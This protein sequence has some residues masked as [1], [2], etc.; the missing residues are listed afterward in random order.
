MDNSM[1]TCSCKYKSLIIIV[2]LLLVNTLAFAQDN[3]IRNF[4]TIG[5][6]LFKKFKLSEVKDIRKAYQER[7]DLYTRRLD[8]LRKSSLDINQAII[9]RKD[10]IVVG[11][12]AILIRLAEFYYEEA[13]EAYFKANENYDL[14]YQKYDSLLTLFDEGKLDAL[15]IEPRPA[16]YDY[17]KPIEVYRRIAND[18]PAGQYAD[19][20][21]YNIAYLYNEMEEGITARKI[22]QELLEKYP[23]SDYA[24]DAYLNLGDYY[25]QPRENK[26][27]DESIVELQK[28]IKLY[29]KILKF[30][31]SKAYSE[32]LYKLGW[33]YYK[34]TVSDSTLYDDAIFYFW[35]SVEDIAMGKKYDPQG[36]ITLANV[37]PEAIEYIAI[38]FSDKRYA[39]DGVRST[40]KFVQ[41]IE[42][43]LGDRDY[44]VLIM[45]S[46]GDKYYEREERENAIRSYETL[47]DMY[48]LY[49]DAPSISKKIVDTYLQD[50]K[51]QQAY[52]ERQRLYQDYNTNSEW[53]KKIE[54]SDYAN[55]FEKLKKAYKMSEEAL[56]ANIF[57]DYQYANENYG[58]LVAQGKYNKV[59][60]EIKQYLALFPIDSSAY[61]LNWALAQIL[62]QKEHRYSEA[63]DEYLKVCNDYY[64][65]NHQ[66]A[67][68]L[69]AISVAQ[70]MAGV[71]SA[72]SDSLTTK[73]VELEALRAQEMN[74]DEQ[75]LIYAFDNYLR[76]FPEGEYAPTALAAAG[77]LYFNNNQFNQAKIYLQT[78]VK[79]FPGAKERNLAYKSIM[80][81]YFALGKYRDSELIANK[82]I[83]MPNV[84]EEMREGAKAR[85][86]ASIFKNAEK[87][88]R[89]KQ[90]V[91]SGYEYRRLA[92]TYPASKF[93]D[94]S[95]V[96]GA[97]AFEEGN[98]WKLAIETYNIL[99]TDFPNSEFVKRA[100]INIA[101]DYKE[102]DDDLA[103]G[104]SY[105]NLYN[106]FSKDDDAEN[107]LYNASLYYEKAKAWEE[108]ILANDLFVNRFPNSPESDFLLFNN[109]GFYLK[110]DRLEDA[111]RIYEEYTRKYPNS[112]RTVEAFF[113]RGEYYQDNQLTEL[114]IAE[115]NRAI[116]KSDRLKSTGKDPNA[117][118]AGEAVYNLVDIQRREFDEIKFGYQNYESELSRKREL[119]KSLAANYQ[120][121]IGYGS[122]RGF[123][124]FYKIAEMYEQVG[125]DIKNK[126]LPPNLPSDQAFV[127][128][129]KNKQSAAQL[130]NVA[131]DEYRKVL[132]FIPNYAEKLDIDLFSES[133]SDTAQVSEIVLVDS[134]MVKK[135]ALQD[136]TKEVGLKWYNKAESKISFLL[137]N[138]ADVH[139]E[140]IEATFN[141]VYDNQQFQGANLIIYRSQLIAKSVIPS[142][143]RAIDAHK[144]NIEVSDELN[145]DNKY[146]E[147]SRRQLLLM[148]NIPAFKY[149]ELVDEAL[150]GW[151]EAEENYR[152]MT[153]K[154]LDSRDAAGKTTFDYDFEAKNYLEY[155]KTLSELGLQRFKETVA[156][157]V[158]DSIRND[159]F[160]TTINKLFQQSY[161]YG[162][163]FY[164]I[165]TKSDTLSKYYRVKFDSSDLNYNYDD[166]SI[167]YE[168]EKFIA[169]EIFRNLLENTHYF[170]QDNG[171]S[172]IWTK[173]ILAR[174]V[175]I[176]PATYA[177]Q[178][179]KEQ[180]IVQSD[181]K[182]KATSD[183]FEGWP[184]RG[185]D[186]SAWAS[187]QELVLHQDSVR[188]AMFDS[189][190]IMPKAIWTLPM[191]ADMLEIS[192]PETIWSE[193]RADSLIDSPVVD[194]P[195]LA[196]STD[197]FLSAMVDSLQQE[198]PVAQPTERTFEVRYLTKLIPVATDTTDTLIAYFRTE[199][200][201]PGRAVNGMM[202][203]T[204]DDDFQLFINN[205][206]IWDDQNNN[207]SVVDSI[208]YFT[209]SQYL[210]EGKNIIGVKVTDLDRAPRLGLRM[211]LRLSYIAGDITDQI[212]Q[213]EQI[214]TIPFEP[215]VLH[216]TL[217]V[218]KGRLIIP[219][220]R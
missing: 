211:Y 83:N 158:E 47:L 148:S 49:V 202:Y 29:R 2:F 54:Q 193:V 205:E 194:S 85:A 24:P 190:Q 15:P 129:F 215:D 41:N 32:A 97:N 90:F 69:N 220:K 55:K 74:E 155:A 149:F 106:A 4:I 157:A 173:R 35:R 82:I 152:I 116:D 184:Q 140:N 150:D 216:K 209:F 67:A 195:A 92:S 33:S 3:S 25:F 137:Y 127:E 100:Y 146:E 118:Y 170:A 68:A 217:L 20:A 132:D 18:Y 188:F 86:A 178:M 145:L 196:D 48:P 187:A 156:M 167:H 8:K 30:P 147:E 218:R 185:Y 21:L 163:K 113:K 169:E 131:V 197:L 198:T 64:E 143:N 105:E 176:D 175:M 212:A 14:E 76:H 115:Y 62:D 10:N 180:L 159:Y 179:P 63:F 165:Y 13:N 66:E 81:S 186:D 166:A 208:S 39:A 79:K 122:V 124:S 160:R 5:D 95:L 40:Q 53:Y 7:Q 98:A 56:R 153:E 164:A 112:P 65:E 6:S 203:M 141:T 128:R 161:E 199:F 78:L 151:E 77:A 70:Q 111:N 46:L 181:A 108:A 174:L 80:E 12:D 121:V 177:S 162:E 138:M 75:R 191:A 99:I 201:L 58:D 36:E 59:V 57:V 38:C 125:D 142:V 61:E 37:E 17:T 50:G 182:T 107:N 136:S 109:A 34:L 11:Q 91:E 22:L 52:I 19:D 126:D 73:K 134:A 200:D 43:K 28:A 192:V 130:Y 139:R 60:D 72:D 171:Y 133:T 89:D 204:G 16:K 206:Y 94:R 110:L 71:V 1:K 44:N 88:Q 117:F 114:A 189:L 102:L 119:L 26:D 31:K 103:V 135:E 219:Q 172:N 144:K 27:V 101:E 120:R 9:D 207:Y 214:E 84:D 154:P 213:E 123:E 42:Q 45:Q 87:Y 96:N 183:Y 93:A 23:D 168:D 51:E 210:V 104:R